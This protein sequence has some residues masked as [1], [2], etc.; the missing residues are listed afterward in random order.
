MDSLYR[1]PALGTNCKFG[2]FPKLP[3]VWII[4]W[5]DWWNSLSAVIL[6]VSVYYREGYTSHHQEK[7]HTR[8]SLGKNQTQSFHCLLSIESRT[9]Y[10]VT[11]QREDVKLYTGYC[12]SGKLTWA[13]VSRVITGAPSHGQC[14][15]NSFIW[16]FS[17]FWSTPLGNWKP[18]LE[19]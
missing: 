17:V 1:P 8:G 10:C 13:S 5:K 16:L 7:K 14:R 3:S 18:H 9:C 15:L 2:D 12:Q 19:S 6:R 4:L 11:L